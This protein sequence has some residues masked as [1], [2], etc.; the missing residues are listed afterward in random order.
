MFGSLL[1]IGMALV[2]LPVT[3]TLAL[4]EYPPTVH[5]PNKTARLHRWIFLAIKFA[6][7][8]PI[9]F[10][11]VLDLA[12]IISSTGI[13]P[14]AMFV[15]YVLS[16]R[17]ALIEQRRRCPVCLQLLTNPVRIGQL[18]HTLLDWY[19]TESMCPKGHGLLHVPESATISFNTQRWLYLDSSWR[20]L[21]SSGNAK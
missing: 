8:L 2:L 11:G 14:H 10:C 15:G 19:G 9:V 17:W 4:G 20:S 6:L 3:T 1:V 18:A 12:P 7:I 13:Q 5:S 16:F 21:F